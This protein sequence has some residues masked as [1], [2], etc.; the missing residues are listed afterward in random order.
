MAGCN[1]K[2]EQAQD[3][4]PAPKP[5]SEAAPA[6][7]EKEVADETHLAQVKE[8]KT[9]AEALLKAWL[10]AQNEGD[11]EAYQALYAKKFEGI[12]RVGAREFHFDHDGWLEDRKALQE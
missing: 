2:E 1:K 6:E 4:A 7:A 3:S 8:A 5:G 10:A 12:K 9:E 11:F